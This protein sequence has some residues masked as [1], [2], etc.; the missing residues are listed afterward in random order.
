MPPNFYQNLAAKNIEIQI[1]HFKSKFKTALKS[2]TEISVFHRKISLQTSE[3][4]QNFNFLSQKSK[5]MVSYQ[6]FLVGSEFELEIVMQSEE[7]QFQNTSPRYAIS[8]HL[9]IRKF[10]PIFQPILNQTATVKIY[11]FPSLWISIKIKRFF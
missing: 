7:I 10:H 4:F 3:K 1:L 11:I 9:R 6:F 5:P 2:D 8:N